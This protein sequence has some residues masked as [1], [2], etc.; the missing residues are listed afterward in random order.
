[1]VPPFP[2]VL[3]DLHALQDE[4]SKDHSLRHGSTL[5]KQINAQLIPGGQIGPPVISRLFFPAF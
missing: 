1:M 2:H 3:T 4:Q 5:G